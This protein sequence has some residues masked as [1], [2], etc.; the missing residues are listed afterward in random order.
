VAEVVAAVTEPAVVPDSDVPDRPPLVFDDDSA[1]NA[2]RPI[3][4]GVGMASV[5]RAFSGLPDHL[6][7]VT[8][9]L[10]RGAYAELKRMAEAGLHGDDPCDAARTIILEGLRRYA[11][12]RP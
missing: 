1:G 6:V 8:I 3:V 9:P 2:P 10:N 12:V 7:L 5:P 4:A 11:M